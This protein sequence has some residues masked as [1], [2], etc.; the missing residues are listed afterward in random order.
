MKQLTRYLATK[1]FD[2][3]YTT[4][5]SNTGEHILKFLATLQMAFARYRG[6]N[7]KVPCCQRRRRRDAVEVRGSSWPR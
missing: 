3:F 4:C 2:N 7:V 5:A 1:D 6:L